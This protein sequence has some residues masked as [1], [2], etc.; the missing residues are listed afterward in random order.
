MT[1][2]DCLFCTDTKTDSI[3]PIQKT[4]KEWKEKNKYGRF[5]MLL[6]GKNNEHKL[7]FESK[8]NGI[9]TS[10]AVEIKNCPMCGRELEN[11][12]ED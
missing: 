1:T 3:F 4:I 2:K 5:Y 12:E 7:F 8:F 10:L 6:N 11:K 9:S